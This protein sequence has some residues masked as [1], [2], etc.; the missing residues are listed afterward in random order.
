MTK[1][2]IVMAGNFLAVP[3]VALACLSSNFYVAMAAFALKILVSGSYF[4]PAITMMQNASKPKDSGFV[5]SCYQFYAHLAQT[6]SPLVF[7]LLAKNMGAMQTPRIYGY[8][9][10]GAVSFGYLLSN[11]FYYKAGRAYKKVME[12][13]E[14]E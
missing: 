6:F 4:A 13:K 8:L 7:S 11:V 3:L 14:A 2:Y 10:L 1:A 9:V 5:V 12:A